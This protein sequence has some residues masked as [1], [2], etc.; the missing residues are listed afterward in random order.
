MNNAWDV[1]IIGAGISGIIAALTLRDEGYDVGV[2]DK[3]HR[4]GGRMATQRVG[5]GQADY[6]AQFFTI[7]RPQFRALAEGWI[8]AG[9]VYQWSSGWSNGSLLGAT[10]VGYPR[11]AAQDGMGALTERLAQDL[12]VETNTQV[13]SITPDGERWLLDDVDGRTFTA[14]LG[15]ILTPPVPQSLELLDQGG[16]LLQA[17][18]R[19]ALEKVEYGPCLCGMFHVEGEIKLPEPG[20]VQTPEGAITWIADN[21]RKGISP[22]ASIIT[23]HASVMFSGAHWDDPAK[24]ILDALWTPVKTYLAHDTRL[25]EARL[26][27]WRH[28]IALNVYPGRYL[29]GNQAPPLLFAGDAFGEPRIEGAA[30]SG[31]NAA[32]ALSNLLR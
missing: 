10:P 16:F 25:I 23:V 24:D 2:I 27:K 18:H 32:E 21:R 6:G 30:L 13:V 4:V 29:I 3:S 20:A 19:R 28:S 15:L 1:I 11:Y 9:W 8:D 22:E 26:K 7:R 31:L 14:E 17:D 5:Q 12:N